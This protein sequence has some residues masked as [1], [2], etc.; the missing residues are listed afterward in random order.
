MTCS[1]SQPKGPSGNRTRNP[2]IKS[3]AFH[4]LRE[5]AVSTRASA[6]H[7]LP[8]GINRSAWHSESRTVKSCGG[9]MRE[10]GGIIPKDA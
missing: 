7:G 1:K 2:S 10:E 8:N 9:G 3:R 5:C 4:H 6:P